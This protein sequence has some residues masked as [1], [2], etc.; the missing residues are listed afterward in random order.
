MSIVSELTNLPEIHNGHAFNDSR[1]VA[2]LRSTLFIADTNRN[3]RISILGP[4]RPKDPSEHDNKEAPKS[5]AETGR[6]QSGL[7][8]HTSVLNIATLEEI[9]HYI[10]SERDV[11]AFFIQKLNS[12]WYLGISAAHFQAICKGVEAPALLEDYILFL[13]KR[14]SDIKRNDSELEIAF[15]PVSLTMRGPVDEEARCLE[16]LCGLRYVDLNDNDL[17]K[18]PLETWSLRQS[19][20]FCASKSKIKR[21]TWLFFSISRA[22]EEALSLL[23]SDTYIRTSMLPFRVLLSLFKVAV[24]NWRFYLAEFAAEMTVHQGHISG[25]LPGPAGPLKHANA[26]VRARL[27]VLEDKLLSTR[28]AIQA[29][30]A[31]LKTIRDAC[32]EVR[33]YFGD[34]LVQDHQRMALAFNSLLRDLDVNMLRVEHLQAKLQ[35]LSTVVSSTLELENGMALQDLAQDS[36]LENEALRG[37]NQEMRDM[38]RK[39]SKD[40]AKIT[41]LT[42]IT[43]VYL[44]LTTMTNF[45]STSFVGTAETHD[46]IFVTDDWWLLLVTAL[47]LTVGTLYVWHVWSNIKTDRSYPAW[48]PLKYRKTAKSPVSH[49]VWPGQTWRTESRQV[50]RSGTF[51]ERD[52]YFRDS[53]EM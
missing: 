48:W 19:M 14:E 11:R 49:Q 27:L 4:L 8:E 51:D 53:T 41:V 15:P 16:V 44:P 45:Y 12:N 6:S 39:T 37:L 7:E 43:L 34:D 20:V 17:A 35:S 40:S 3:V 1:M 26:E 22:S 31:D 24:G 52:A 33:S 5:A 38:A 10:V 21:T 2:R 47:P 42:I 50:E 25:T 46:A 18:Y 32:E 23:W 29:T 28:L 36:K 13:G 9:N 30:H